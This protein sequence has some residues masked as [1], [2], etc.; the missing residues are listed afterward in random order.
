MFW[1][2]QRLAKTAKAI[3]RSLHLDLFGSRHLAFGI[4]MRFGRS[5]T[6]ARI[7]HQL[8]KGSLR[9][10]SAEWAVTDWARYVSTFQGSGSVTTRKP[11]R[12]RSPATRS[13]SRTHIEQ[14]SAGASSMYRLIGKARCLR[15]IIKR[16]GPDVGANWKGQTRV[17]N[18]LDVNGSGWF[19]GLPNPVRLHSSGI[20]INRAIRTRGDCDAVA[21]SNP[22]LPT[23]TEIPLAFVVI[24]LASAC[25][26]VVTHFLLSD[27][28][29]D[30][31]A[32]LGR[33]FPAHTC[34]NCS[35]SILTV[36]RLQCSEHRIGAADQAH[37]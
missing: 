34:G 19:R 17:R 27:R 12:W 15:Q 35:R 10:V 4:C 6:S 23:T 16:R 7:G 37:W 22:R 21:F 31:K 9:H 36:A 26:G 14:A 32:I 3:R 24:A 30:C 5:S 2:S 18:F 28:D 13:I 1:L 8:W 20:G 25:Q 29:P 33:S 11:I